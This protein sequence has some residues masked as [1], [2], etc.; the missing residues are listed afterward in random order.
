VLGEE[1]ERLVVLFRERQAAR[2]RGM[3]TEM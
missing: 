3:A 1:M 2:E